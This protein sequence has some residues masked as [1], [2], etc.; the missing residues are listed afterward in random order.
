MTVEELEFEGVIDPNYK[1][2]SNYAI[3]KL[4]QDSAKKCSN[5]YVATPLQPY[6]LD[7]EYLNSATEDTRELLDKNICLIASTKN[8]RKTLERFSFAKKENN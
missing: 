7:T 2:R 8:T 5:S 4:T 6:K 1:K 3:L